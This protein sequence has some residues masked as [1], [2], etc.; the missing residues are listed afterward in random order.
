[1][2]VDWTTVRGVERIEIGQLVAHYRLMS[3]MDTRAASFWRTMA[4]TAIRTFREQ[5]AQPE[6]LAA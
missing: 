4:R 5:N 2:T 3:R 1:M 6:R